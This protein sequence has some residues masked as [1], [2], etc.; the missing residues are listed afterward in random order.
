MTLRIVTKSMQSLQQYSF[1]QS[2]SREVKRLGGMGKKYGGFI[3]NLI[4]EFSTII[5]AGKSVV[6]EKLVL[7]LRD[8]D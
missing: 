3:I 1:E 4:L 6:N 2:V 7:F 5:K 8:V